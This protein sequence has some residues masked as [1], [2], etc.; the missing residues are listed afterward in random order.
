MIIPEKVVNVKGL[1][2]VRDE[3]EKILG[4][5]VKW[6]PGFFE[7]DLEDVINFRCD[8]RSAKLIAEI[9]AIL[10]SAHAISTPPQGPLPSNLSLWLYFNPGLSAD[11]LLFLDLTI[12]TF[13]PYES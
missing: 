1:Y 2:E 10:V 13:N 6:R 9:F 4:H 12:M 7:Y 8:A 11:F 5:S 3:I